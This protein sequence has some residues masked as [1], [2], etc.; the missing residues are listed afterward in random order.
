MQG[1]RIERIEPGEVVGPFSIEIPRTAI[2]YALFCQRT[3]RL[4]RW[5]WRRGFKRRELALRMADVMG[6]EAGSTD[7]V[8]DNLN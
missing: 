8:L 6:D 2:L 5:L 1:G 4:E 3:T 7:D